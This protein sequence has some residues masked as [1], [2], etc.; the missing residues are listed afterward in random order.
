MCLI[1]SLY[2][3]LQTIDS[4]KIICCLL[5]SIISSIYPKSSDHLINV[6][7]ISI[8]IKRYIDYQRKKLN[9]DKYY[10]VSFHVTLI[11][12]FLFAYESMKYIGN[13]Y[14]VKYRH[15]F[16]F[17]IKVKYTLGWHCVLNLNVRRSRILRCKEIF[18]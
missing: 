8:D 13:K 12:L 10:D 18:W 4:K 6:Q 16:Y 1:L 11:F 2:N 7:I 3:N 15:W 5:L 17:G 14:Q 9:S